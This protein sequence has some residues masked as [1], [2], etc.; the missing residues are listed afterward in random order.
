MPVMNVIEKQVAIVQ[1]FAEFQNWEDRYKHLIQIGRSLP[2][3]PD[4]DKTDDAKVRGCSSSVWLHAE[5]ADDGTVTLRADS[6]AILVRG[7]VAL[8]LR[9]YSGERPAAIIDTD[10]MFIEELEL[11][12]HL[13]QT[14]ANGLASMVKQIKAY[15]VAFAA[16]S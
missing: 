4:A 10:P 5:L 16:R 2:D 7:L 12:Q 6:D 11:T 14:R 8:L 3:L 15:A 1:E 13:T 9:V